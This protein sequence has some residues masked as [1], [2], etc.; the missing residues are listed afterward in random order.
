M[1]TL[2]QKQVSQD[3]VARIKNGDKLPTL[4]AA[5]LQLLELVNDAN[6]A[7]AKIATIVG[8]DPV[9]AAKVLKV[10]NSSLFGA[11]QRITSLQ[12]AIVALGMRSLKTLSMS[13][14]LIGSFDQN[15]LEW[16][17][18]QGFWRRSVTQ[19]VAA[20]LLAKRCAPELCDEAFVCGLLSNLGILA[21]AQT[22]RGEYAA[23]YRHAAGDH[24][25][26]LEAEQSCLGVDHA[27][28][29]YALFGKWKLPES[30]R[31]AVRLHHRGAR[32]DLDAETASLVSLVH[33]AAQV[34]DLFCDGTCKE[35]LEAAYA[36][37]ETVLSLGNKQFDTILRDLDGHVKESASLLSVDIGKTTNYDALQE[38][39]AVE[40][41]L[42]AGRQPRQD[43]LSPDAPKISLTDELSGLP[44]RDAFDRYVERAFRQAVIA[45]KPLGLLLCG[46]DAFQ[47]T[48]DT[49][50]P[51][52]GDL[53]VTTTGESLRAFEA[54]GAYV[55]RYGDGEFALLFTDCGL[56]R[57]RALA[58]NL[59]QRFQSGSVL[60]SKGTIRFKVVATGTSSAAQIKPNLPELLAKAEEQLGKIQPCIRPAAV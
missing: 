23:A 45:G 30:L 15:R 10:A 11:S 31:I 32:P 37:V 20:K 3:L 4:P 19:A 21:M 54:Q 58:G 27:E 16:F 35:G 26:L 41:D 59:A 57:A 33:V 25:A 22:L 9:V 51:S 34:A 38:Q 49:Y 1:V 44:S 7:V 12:Q 43:A 50:G 5:A 29:A 48:K 18:Y 24:M 42:P 55:A 40:I 53:L 28:V 46:I 60:C 2:G 8:H 47:N 6:A 17:D 52:V 14:S 36:T 56:D 13:L 39:A